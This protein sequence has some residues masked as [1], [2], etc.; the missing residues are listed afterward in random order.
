[1]SNEREI[2]EVLKEEL[3]RYSQVWEDHTM[4]EQGLCITED[5]NVLSIASA[6]CNALALLLQGANSVTA[7]DLNATQTSVLHLKKA[8]IQAR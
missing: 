2:H 4:L 6:G 8:A 5:D 3:I 7:V 1:M